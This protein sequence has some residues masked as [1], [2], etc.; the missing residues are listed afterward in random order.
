MGKSKLSGNPL[1][2]IF[3]ICSG[4]AVSEKE[5][6]PDSADVCEVPKPLSCLFRGCLD[7]VKHDKAYN[8]IRLG[9]TGKMLAGSQIYSFCGK[10]TKRKIL[11]KTYDNSAFTIDKSFIG[12][13]IMDVK[14]CDGENTVAIVGAKWKCFIVSFGL[15][16]P[17]SVSFE[18]NNFIGDRVTRCNGETVLKQKG[19]NCGDENAQCWKIEFI[20]NQSL[21]EA[22]IVSVDDVDLFEPVTSEVEN[23]IEKFIKQNGFLNDKRFLTTSYLRQT[24]TGHEEWE[25]EDMP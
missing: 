16:G 15:C 3:L 17:D 11:I 22:F 1:H 21:E 8:V 4:W 23:T 9:P 20:E 18:P 12:Q 6:C 5:L 10:D 7:P 19:D 14:P 2:L 13:E 25:L 24:C